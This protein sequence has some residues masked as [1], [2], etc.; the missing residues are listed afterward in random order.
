MTRAKNLPLLKRDEASNDATAL[1]LAVYWL[2]RKFLLNKDLRLIL[3]STDASP[4]ARILLGS[5]V[6][7]AL[8]TPWA[9]SLA[10]R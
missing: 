2:H 9:H 5:A 3:R 1:E 8:E 10:N 7:R 6:L 4:D